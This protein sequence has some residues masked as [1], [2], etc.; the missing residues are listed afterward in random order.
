M[1]Q[2]SPSRFQSFPMI[3][4]W[5]SKEVYKTVVK[6]EP[7]SPLDSKPSVFQLTSECLEKCF[8]YSLGETE[9]GGGSG[10]RRSDAINE[11]KYKNI[12]DRQCN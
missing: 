8:P 5:V 4:L 3:F 1:T 12:N 9:G 10:D 2:A 6:M 11:P 7:Q